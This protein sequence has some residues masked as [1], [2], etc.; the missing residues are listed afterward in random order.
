MAIKNTPWL[1]PKR[2]W[3]LVALCML[4]PFASC[5]GKSDKPQTEPSAVTTGLSFDSKNKLATMINLSGQL[6]ASVDRVSALGRDRYTVA[7][8][9]YR[10]GT[11]TATYEIDLQTGTVK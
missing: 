2:F 7:C 10:D 4:L 9:K 11:G 5:V 1:T 8:T 3:L 6:C